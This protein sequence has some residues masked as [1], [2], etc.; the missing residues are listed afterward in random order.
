[1]M[2]VRPG[3]W[4]GPFC[5]PTLTLATPSARSSGLSLPSACH[6]SR[7]LLSSGQ[8]GEKQASKTTGGTDAHREEGASL[9]FLEGHAISESVSLGSH[10]SQLWGG[11]TGTVLGFPHSASICSLPIEAGNVNG[12]E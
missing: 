8:K 9:P 6:F 4:S 7:S 1:M 12:F 3:G 10:L 2:L 11:W 5:I